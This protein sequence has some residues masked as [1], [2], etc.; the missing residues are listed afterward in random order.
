MQPATNLIELW[1]ASRA[2]HLDRPLIGSKHD[3]AWRWTSYRQFGD[4]VDQIRGGLAGL[5]VQTG[6]RVAIIANNSLE[7]AAAA[8]ATYG[9][10]ATFV[11]MYEAQS[12]NEWQ[13]I[14]E[15]CGARV[16]IA[17]SESIYSA[18]Q[19]MRDK[20]PM[21]AH[22]VGIARPGDAT[23]SW[24]RLAAA[25]A[26]HP[27]PVSQP[28]PNEIASFIYTSGTTGKP[29]GVRLSHGN[30]TSNIQA[31]LS[32]F[33]FEPSD[34]SLSFLPWAHVYG[35][36]CD[37]HIVIGYGG[38]TAINDELPRLFQNLAEVKPTLFVAV[39]RVYNRLYTAMNSQLGAA[40]AAPRPLKHSGV[41]PAP[42][43]A[44]PPDPL[45]AAPAAPQAP[46]IGQRIR[47]SFGGRLKYAFS[48]SATLAKEVA[49]F[50]DAAGIR[51]FEGY[52]LT[53]TSPTVTTNSPAGQRIGSVGRAVPGVRIVIDTSVTKQ[54]VEGEIVV[55]GPNVMAGYH[56][57]PAED[58][59]VFTADGGLRTGDLGHL[60]DDGY[61]YI[62]GRIKEQYKLENG[63][64][65][66]PSLLEE[67]LKLSPFI[68]NAFIYGDGR[69]FNVALIVPSQPEIRGW[70]VKRELVLGDDLTVDEQV[71]GLVAAELARLGAEFRSFE[72]PHDFVLLAQ[73]F[74]VDN[75]LLT[76]TLKLKRR[77]VQIRYASMLEQL[78]DRKPAAPSERTTALS[79]TPS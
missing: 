24:A 69:P 9:L 35:Q 15:D 67:Q 68:A 70:A 2:A 23:D 79:S 59:K 57:R 25:G 36:M 28:E 22:V 41:L 71:R 19:R 65:V 32:L 33:P 17:A 50:I 74:T 72:R 49:E 26:A 64:Y 29:K 73:D 66:M 20:L 21:L 11:P 10:R 14:L 6:D 63:K 39:P 27:V 34:R 44:H 30:M 58:S 46:T 48:G 61:L 77:E 13:I 4:L 42:G 52:G 31:S 45:P 1:Q 18:I 3:G 55:Y 37:L 16:A 43:G 12:P 54:R 53:E 40:P 47:D 7:W 38:S 51:V 75:G 62:T 5:G 60:D 76:P 8:Y 78:Y 56:D